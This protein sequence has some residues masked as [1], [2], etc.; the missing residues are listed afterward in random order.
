MR[1]PNAVQSGSTTCVASA[2]AAARV[3]MISNINE[4]IGLVRSTCVDPS[5]VED[6][7]LENYLFRM[8]LTSLEFR[9]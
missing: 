2:A 1:D 7:M 8:S 9:K 5:E 4:Y 6:A 3:H